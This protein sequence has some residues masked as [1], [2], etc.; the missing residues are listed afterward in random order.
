MTIHTVRSVLSRTIRPAAPTADAPVHLVSNAVAFAAAAT[1]IAE[2]VRRAGLSQNYW[3]DQRI[4]KPDVHELLGESR[5]EMNQETAARM[6]LI[7]LMHPEMPSD[8]EF[9]S[10]T[11]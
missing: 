4:T 5:V 1:W 3:D 11:E 10:I 2:I 8:C 7:G 9:A 6:G